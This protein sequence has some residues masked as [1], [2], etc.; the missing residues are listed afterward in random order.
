M[1]EK[2]T[3]IEGQFGCKMKEVFVSDFEQLLEEEVEI[4]CFSSHE[5]NLQGPGVLFFFS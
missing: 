1:N 4:V 3:E 2:T 5:L